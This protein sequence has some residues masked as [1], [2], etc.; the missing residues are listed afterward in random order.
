MT[1]GREHSQVWEQQSN[2]MDAE[3]EELTCVCNSGTSET[4]SEDRLR[5]QEVV[6]QEYGK[7]LA[8]DLHV[9]LRTLDCPLENRAHLKKREKEKKISRE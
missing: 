9:M 2:G 6:I 4:T 8:P 5:K 7:D 1:R 3:V